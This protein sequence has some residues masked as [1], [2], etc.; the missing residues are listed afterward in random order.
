MSTISKA[1]R[2]VTAEFLAM[3]T[4]S[5]ARSSPT[6]P[7]DQPARRLHR[8]FALAVSVLGKW[9]M[10]TCTTA[11]NNFLTFSVF[12]STYGSGVQT[13]K[14]AQTAFCLLLKI[15]W[16]S[17]SSS[18]PSPSSLTVLPNMSGGLSQHLNVVSSR[19]LQLFAWLRRDTC[20]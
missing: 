3:R 11:P 10:L 1:R 18:S 5:W 16:A 4:L 6:I 13:H 14:I 19:F 15:V 12:I 2:N 7:T 17:S 20:V 9:P 8:K